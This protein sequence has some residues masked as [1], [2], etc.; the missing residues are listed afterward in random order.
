MEPGWFCR[1]KV[2]KL[3]NKKCLR[4][5][6]HIVIMYIYIYIHIIKLFAHIIFFFIILFIFIILKSSCSS[7]IVHHVC[8]I[9]YMI[10]IIYFIPTW[11]LKPSGPWPKP[12]NLA[13][14]QTVTGSFASDSEFL[15]GYIK[16]YVFMQI[17]YTELTIV[18]TNSYIAH[19]ALI[20]YWHE[21]VIGLVFFFRCYGTHPLY[22][23]FIH[24]VSHTGANFNT[25]SMSHSF[26]KSNM[27]QMATD[28][29][30]LSSASFHQAWPAKHSWSICNRCNGNLLGLLQD[31]NKKL[32][33]IC[34][35]VVPWS[36]SGP[37]NGLHINHQISTCFT[38]WLELHE[39]FAAKVP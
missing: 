14:P 2:Q 9:M 21:M 12:D 13:W 18:S 36:N 29:K 22:S 23:V 26:A 7:C 4:H 3:K 33:S 37:P 25:L 32:C 20:S 8:F 5:Y 35:Q 28:T 38:C 31:L 6:H 27:L 17:E 11:N 19:G 16:I 1:W 39:M 24:H 10:L 34:C 15:R 30:L